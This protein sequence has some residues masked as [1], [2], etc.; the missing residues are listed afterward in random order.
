MIEFSLCA[1]YK[2]EDQN[3]EKFITDHR[4]HVAEMV[5]V[6]TGSSDRSNEIVRAA[7]LEYHFFAWPGNFAEARNASLK[8][9]TKPWVIVLD[10]DE[11]VLPEDFQ[12]LKEVMLKT[13]KDAYSLR[14]INFSD[15][16]E[17][18]NWRSSDGLPEQFRS[19]AQGYIESPLLRVFRNHRG[20]RFHGAIH[21]LIGESVHQL[22]MS[23]MKTDVPIY[24]LG[25][26]GAARTDE[27]K[28]RK[29]RAYRLL[30]KQEWEREPSAKNAFYYLST[31]EDAQEKLRLGFQLSR[32]FPEVKQFWEELARSAADLQQWERALAYVEKGL[33]LHPGLVPLLA[34]KL[35]CLN[36][37]A[38]PEEALATADLLLA[39]DRLHPIFWFEKFRALIMLQRRDQAEALSADLPP[40]FPRY[41]ADRLMAILEQK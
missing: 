22:K 27:E 28:L 14:Q 30:I 2:D 17:D 9:P 31:L 4:D 19:L 18:I 41:L 25:W 38:R 29:K 15:A 35:R 37:T 20:V 11:Q 21:E 1:I 33:H 13:G 12:R 6:D 24:H 5:L 8:L 32:R 40:R 26:T 16:F 10:I 7:G 3:L 23:S 36:E 34:V 39:G